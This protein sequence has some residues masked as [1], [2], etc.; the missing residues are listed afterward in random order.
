MSTAEEFFQELRGT[1]V[2]T[3]ETLSL[4]LL[5]A[6]ERLYNLVDARNSEQ[7]F[8]A[9]M[10]RFA[11]LA[12]RWNQSGSRWRT[13]WS[14]ATTQNSAPSLSSSP[15]TPSVSGAPGAAVRDHAQDHRQRLEAA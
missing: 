7:E 13:H 12:S 4:P 6:A 14:T 10:R 11:I 2:V 8:M 5:R 1:D 9:R 15:T 3:N